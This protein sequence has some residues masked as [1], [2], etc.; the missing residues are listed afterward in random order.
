MAIDG[1]VCFWRGDIFWY[2][3]VHLVGI[4]TRALIATKSNVGDCW[5]RGNY[6]QLNV[7]LFAWNTFVSL[8][9]KNTGVPISH[10]GVTKLKGRCHLSF[11]Y[12]I[13]YPSK[14]TSPDMHDAIGGNVIDHE[15]FVVGCQSLV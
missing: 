2:I 5:R 8:G 7:A 11:V 9:V 1:P 12:S 14:K 4:K 13:A 10:V 3:K 15:R 6:T